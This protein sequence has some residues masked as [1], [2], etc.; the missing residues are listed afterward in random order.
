MNCSNLFLKTTL[1]AN[2]WIGVKASTSKNLHEVVESLRNVT[3]QNW[4]KNRK[5]GKSFVLKTL[6]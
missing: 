2:G 3:Y 6:H 4:L 1:S 5:Y